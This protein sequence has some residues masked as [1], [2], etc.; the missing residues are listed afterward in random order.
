MPNSECNFIEGSLSAKDLRFGIIIARFNSFITERLLEGAL[1]AIQRSDGDVSIVDVVRVPGSLEI[2]TVAQSMAE[3][4][5][6]DALICLGAVIRGKTTHF[7]HVS[8][9]AENGISS[10]G[11]R[12]K[13]PTIFGVLTCNTVEQAIDRAGGKSGNAGSRAAMAAIE[14]A[15][16]MQKLSKDSS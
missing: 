10:I 16:L 7:E 6:Y 5:K 3:S 13:V 2:A 14:M 1:D 9:G 12:T 11:P 8:S 15:N 4:K